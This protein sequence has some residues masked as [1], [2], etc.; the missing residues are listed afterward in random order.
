TTPDLGQRGISTFVVERGTP[1]LGTGRKIEKL[2]LHASD[3]A[4]VVFDNVRLP[5]GHMV[6]DESQGFAQALQI[7]NGGRV[8]IAAWCLGIGRGALE[9]SAVWVRERTSSR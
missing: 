1:G 6:G 3:T 9:S 5:P 4:E 8:G 7:L 2:G